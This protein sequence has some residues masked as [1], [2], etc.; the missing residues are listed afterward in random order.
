MSGRI[1]VVA[2]REFLTTIRRKA[3]VITTLGMPL[4]IL[5]YAG[6]AMLPALFIGELPYR[7]TAR[8]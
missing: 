2:R 7:S 3:Y 5:L 6:I 4:F 1:G 8:P